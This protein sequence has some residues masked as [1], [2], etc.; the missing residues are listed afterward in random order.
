MVFASSSSATAASAVSIHLQPDPQRSDWQ[1]DHHVTPAFLPLPSNSD[2][3]VFMTR[4]RAGG[5][6]EEREPSRAKVGGKKRERGGT[7][8]FFFFFFFKKGSGMENC[9][10]LTTVGPRLRQDQLDKQNVK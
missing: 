10:T 9:G 2:D 8:C 5:G 3:D 4:P 1:I 7:R 6:E